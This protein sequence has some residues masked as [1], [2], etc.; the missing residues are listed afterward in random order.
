MQLCY[1]KKFYKSFA[2][3]PLKQQ[4]KTLIVLKKFQSDPFARKLR[5]HK[6]QGKFK[7]KES[8]D[9]TGDLRI[10]IEPKTHEIVDVIDVGSHSRLY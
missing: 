6:L 10:I 1:R 8:L 7:G 5:R 3:L 9:V 2:K 4:E